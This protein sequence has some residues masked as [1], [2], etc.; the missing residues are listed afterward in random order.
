MSKTRL[1]L[2]V[3]ATALV[4]ALPGV[5][6]AQSAGG[7]SDA[8]VAWGGDLFE[9][10]PNGFTLTGR[11][12]LTQ[13]GNRLR[14]NRINFVTANGDLTQAE[15]SGEVYFVTPEQTMRGDRAVY[16]LGT[17]NVTVT[18]DVILTQGQNVV[19]GGRLVYNVATETARMEG[20]PTA[21]GNRVRGVFYPQGSN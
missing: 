7:A 17:D 11:A 18:G 13:G 6:G 5:G 1:T 4:A 16:D 3:A 10:A 12:E 8:P 20:A 2:L 15:A 14:A 19:T 9:Y 21:Q